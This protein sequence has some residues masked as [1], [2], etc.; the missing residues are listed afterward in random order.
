MKIKALLNRGTGVIYV[1]VKDVVKHLQ[2]EKANGTKI[3][4]IDNIIDI[5]TDLL[6]Q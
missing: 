4:S 3:V 2:T 6:L 5:F 1:S